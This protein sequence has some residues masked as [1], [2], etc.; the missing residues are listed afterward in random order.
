MEAT[1]R[2][3][4]NETSSKGHVGHFVFDY[5]SARIFESIERK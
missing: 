3:V 1:F 5:R 4:D 2:S